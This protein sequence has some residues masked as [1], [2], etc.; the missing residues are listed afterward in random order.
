MT[1]WALLCAMCYGVNSFNITSSYVLIASSS[2]IMV[3]STPLLSLPKWSVEA[4]ICLETRVWKQ[5]QYV[6][7]N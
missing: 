6:C 3:L 2:L 5:E 7:D 4:L 1:A